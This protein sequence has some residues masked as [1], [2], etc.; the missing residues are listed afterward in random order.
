MLEKLKQSLRG[1]KETAAF[2]VPGQI[3]DSSRILALASLDLSDLLFHV[4]LLSAIRRTWPGASLDFLVPDAFA[5][6][7]IPSG[8]ARQVM[9]Y[10][11]KQLVGWKPALRNLQRSLAGG[12]YDASFVLSLEPAPVLED[13]G[14]TSGA[15][16]RCGPSHPGAWPAVNL[17]LRRGDEATGYGG[18]SLARLAPFLGLDPGII[19]TAWPLPTDKLRQ[20]AQLVHFNKPRPEEVLV[21]IDPG[22]DKAGRALSVANLVFLVQQLK[23]QLTC[24]ILPLAGPGG[25]DRLREFETALGAPVPPAFNRDTLLETILLLCQCDLF[26]AGNTDLFHVAVAEGVPTVG[27]FGSAVDP[28]WQPRNRRRC[29]VLNAS[30]GEKVDMATLMDAV[31]AVRAPE[32]GRDTAPA[33]GDG[34]VPGPIPAPGA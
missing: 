4:P 10:S 12:R 19:R 13:L 33:P 2:R 18:D 23:T 15:V 27:L 6:L 29:A 32:P 31:N 14:L 25:E 11:E 17:E 28:R 5:P 26:V 21:G 30:R 16:L 9:V 8:L 3:S 24:R 20:V 7:V 22:P 34:A 1:R